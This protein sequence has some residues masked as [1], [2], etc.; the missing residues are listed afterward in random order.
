MGADEIISKIDG[1]ASVEVDKIIQEANTSREKVL[2]EAKAE[3]ERKKQLILE[4]G[5]KDAILEKQRILADAK[6]KAKRFRWEAQE[7]LIGQVLDAATDK[8]RKVRSDSKYG[9]ILK[10]LIQEAASSIGE[11]ELEVVF[12]EGDSVDLE[13]ISGEIG[14]KLSCSDDTISGMGGVVV[15]TTDGRIEVDNTFERRIERFTEA[16][17]SEITITLFGG[18]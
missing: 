8:V 1:R 14:V 18:V 4:K 11:D 17:R 9:D 10:G 2:D 12:T 7:D 16:L 6:L 15:R 3:A 13:K 5:E